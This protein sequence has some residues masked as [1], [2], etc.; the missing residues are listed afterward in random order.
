MGRLGADEIE[1]QACLAECAKQVWE[2][3]E[4][5]VNPSCKERVCRGR[6]QHAQAQRAGGFNRFAHS[7]G[8]YHYLLVAGC[9]VA[10]LLVVG[11]VVG[12]WLVVRLLVCSV[13]R[14]PEHVNKDFPGRPP[15]HVN[16]DF[17]GRRAEMT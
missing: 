6:L 2:G 13:S 4:G 14:A 15:E 10:W 17:P 8:P 9:L 7:A 12:R 1:L 16:K 11:L 5:R 3:K